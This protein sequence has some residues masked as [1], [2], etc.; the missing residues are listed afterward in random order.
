MSGSFD[1]VSSAGIPDMQKTDPILMGIAGALSFGIV[2][3][4][5]AWAA[6]AGTM[7]EAIAGLVGALVGGVYGYVGQALFGE[8]GAYRVQ[9]YQW[10][11][12]CAL[13]GAVLFAAQAAG[14]AKLTGGLV[15]LVAG[16]LVG[17][18]LSTIHSSIAAG[19]GGLRSSLVS[20]LGPTGGLAVFGGLAVGGLAWALWSR[21]SRGDSH[22]IIAGVIAGLIFAALVAA[23]AWS[24]SDRPRNGSSWRPPE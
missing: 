9:L 10:V 17:L 23:N 3:A 8:G 20:K 15:G 12:W 22:A 4:L 21:W 19:L 1:A 6:D 16:A 7:W 5:L 13:L 2:S 24:R 14:A 18:V 11:V